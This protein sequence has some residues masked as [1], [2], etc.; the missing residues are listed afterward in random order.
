MF[1]CCLN[2]EPA[3][4]ELDGAG[5]SRGRIVRW[6]WAIRQIASTQP[7]PGLAGRV[8]DRARDLPRAQLPD[9]WRRRDSRNRSRTSRSIMPR[10]LNG[11]GK[12]GFEGR[13]GIRRCD[14]SPSLRRGKLAAGSRRDE[15]ASAATR[16]ATARSALPQKAH[17]RG[18]NPATVVAEVPPLQDFPQDA[19]GNE[20]A[21]PARAATASGRGRNRPRYRTAA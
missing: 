10:S 11:S 3:R 7:M 19:F 14:E 1:G 4:I 13:P 5:Q 16:P 9:R 17:R 12:C 18:V 21:R 8:A 2:R 15:R 6:S 20:P